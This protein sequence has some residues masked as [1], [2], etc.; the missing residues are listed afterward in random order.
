MDHFGLEVRAA[1]EAL[2]EAKVPTEGPSGLTLTL[3][4]RIRILW[5]AKKAAFKLGFNRGVKTV[6]RK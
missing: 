1:H 4:E 2:D 3:D 6:M 5:F